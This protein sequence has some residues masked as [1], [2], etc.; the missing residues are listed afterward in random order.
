MDFKIL[1]LIS[2]TSF[3]RLSHMYRIERQ[4]PND[5]YIR[6]DVLERGNIRSAIIVD[7][8]R[9]VPIERMEI[10]NCLYCFITTDLY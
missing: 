9:D 4:Y 5:Y 6:R 8:G 3:F 7:N 1:L 10:R 2:F